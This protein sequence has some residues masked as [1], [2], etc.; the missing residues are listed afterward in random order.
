MDH[1]SVVGIHIINDIA[2]VVSQ[3]SYFCSVVETLPFLL[4]ALFILLACNMHQAVWRS[5]AAA[6][7]MGLTCRSYPVM[8]LTLTL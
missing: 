6:L 1:N 2:S 4:I 5:R 7:A 8:A 3:L